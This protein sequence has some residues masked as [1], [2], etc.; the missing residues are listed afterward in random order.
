M[1][2]GVRELAGEAV[3]AGGQFVTTDI[4]GYRSGGARLHYRL[5]GGIWRFADSASN[6]RSLRQASCVVPDGCC[7]LA[8]FGLAW[9]V[10]GTRKP[11]DFHG[12]TIVFSINRAN[13]EGPGVLRKAYPQWPRERAR[14]RSSHAVAD[15]V[16]VISPRNTPNSRSA[17]NTALNCCVYAT[18]S[19]CVKCCGLLA[20]PRATGGSFGR[21]H[22]PRNQQPQ[23]ASQPS[24]SAGTGCA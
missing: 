4:R 3:P 1:V 8:G 9:T 22:R 17:V 16:S 24:K 11:G 18:P 5:I 15:A 13:Q 14:F 6:C 19:F 21:H 20:N 12:T 7:L 10:R 23:R 2:I